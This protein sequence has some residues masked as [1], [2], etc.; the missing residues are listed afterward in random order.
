MQGLIPECYFLF[1]EETEWCYRAK[2]RG[3]KI[4]S[5]GTAHIRHKGSV[6]IKQ[7]SGLNDYLLFRNECAFI[8]RNAMNILFAFFTYKYL[9]LREYAKY[10]IRRKKCYM[11]NL[12]ALKD[13][14]ENKFDYEKYPFIVVN[15]E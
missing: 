1:F 15:E 12:K 13:G 10:V 11:D 6:S 4:I 14:W 2:K 9:S 7:I 3:Y 8:R 5:L